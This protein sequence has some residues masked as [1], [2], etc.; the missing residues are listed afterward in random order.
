LN[1][2]SPTFVNKDID[3]APSSIAGTAASFKPAAWRGSA[4]QV[5]AFA[6]PMPFIAGDGDPCSEN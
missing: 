3:H 5:R 4:E 6:S 1:I 2:G